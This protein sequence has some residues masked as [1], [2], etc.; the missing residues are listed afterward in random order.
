MQQPKVPYEIQTQI[1]HRYYRG[2]RVKDLALEYRVHPQTIY[3]YVRR[4]GAPSR[5]E[6]NAARATDR[7]EVALLLAEDWSWTYER[8]GRCLGVSRQR[9]H[10]LLERVVAESSHD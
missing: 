10:Q 9:V 7:M 6:L 2:D 3:N 4:G 1:Q 8:I 5:H